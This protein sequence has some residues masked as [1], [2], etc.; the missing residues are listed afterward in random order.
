MSVEHDI[1]RVKNYKI[2]TRPYGGTEA[3]FNREL[4]IVTGLVN[5]HTLFSEIRSGTGL[6]GTLM[7]ERRRERLKRHRRR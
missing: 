4:N 3:E 6:Y 1:G 7:A 5:F 2:L